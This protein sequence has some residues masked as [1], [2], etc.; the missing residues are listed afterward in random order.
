MMKAAP[1]AIPITPSVAMNGGSRASTISAALRS[2][3]ARP[4]RSPIATLAPSGQLAV[5]NRSAI[6]T[7]VSAMTAPGARS[8]PPEMITIAAPTAAIP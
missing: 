2:P 1:R 3:A 4:T 7:P 8:I 6:T 5:T